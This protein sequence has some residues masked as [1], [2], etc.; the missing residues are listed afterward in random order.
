MY[1]FGRSLTCDFQLDHPSISRQH[2]ALVHHTKGGLYLIDLKS[3]HCTAVNG[4]RLRPFEAVLLKQ[5]S[6]LT[7]GASSR[8]YRL[9]GVLPPP[10]P[11]TAPSDGELAAAVGPTLPGAQH[12]AEH[13]RKYSPADAKAKKRHKW[14]RDEKPRS[15]M[16]E[17]E[18]VAMGAGAGS[19][20]F[21]PGFD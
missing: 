8:T 1:T 5:G 17:N 6:L 3:S 7:F 16:T 9:E 20:C 4:T 2:A 13:K 18:R 12:G 11:A 15:K 19:G 21:G 14:L 10:P